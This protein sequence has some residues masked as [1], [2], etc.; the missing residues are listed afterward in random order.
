M[1]LQECVLL[2]ERC[3]GGG[4]AGTA[5]IGGV[6]AVTGGA[7]CMLWC[8]RR[9]L[10][11][12]WCPIASN[13][14][15][16]LLLVGAVVGAENATDNDVWLALGAFPALVVAAASWRDARARGG[17]EAIGYETDLES[18]AESLPPQPC[19]GRKTHRRVRSV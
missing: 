6:C 14:L 16:S 3:E 9:R 2:T 4:K 1:W 17:Y 7:M 8:W 18:V 19:D 10:A 12:R 15:F 13:A 11:A 5:V